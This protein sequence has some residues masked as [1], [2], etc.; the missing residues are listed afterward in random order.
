MPYDHLFGPFD[1]VGELF[2]RWVVHLYLFVPPPS[3]VFIANIPGYSIQ[4]ARI[5]DIVTRKHQP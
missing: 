1:V 3:S 2:W 4:Q 5:L